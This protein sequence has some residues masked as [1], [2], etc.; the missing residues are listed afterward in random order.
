MSD[1]FATHIVEPGKLALFLMLVA[2]IVTFLFIRFSVRMIRA[3]VSWWPGNVQPGGLHIHHVVFGLVFMLIAGVLAFAPAAWESPWWEIMGALFGIGAAL[4]LDEFALILHLDDVYWSEQGRKSIDV[5]FL[6]AALVGML[7]LGASP[8]GVAGTS[9]AEESLRWAWVGTVVINGAFVVIT[10]LKGRLWLGVLG[11]LLPLL[12]LIGTLLI[13]KP[14]SPWA[15]RRYREG[16]R[17]RSRSV[18]RAARH[19]VRWQELK[20]RVFDAVAGRP[21][22]PVVP[23]QRPGDHDLTLPAADAAA[24]A[25]VQRDDA[26]G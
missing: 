2:F 13:A 12:A 23:D 6:C 9:E 20:H 11:L 3:G 5:V 15:R 8:L 21:D 22:A 1:W 26:R 16:S 7:V 17:K 14:E 25:P 19:D 4:V 24:S 18:A 10:L